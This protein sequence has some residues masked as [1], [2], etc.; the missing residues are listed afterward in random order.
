MLPDHV[1]VSPCKPLAY[2]PLI[3]KAQEVLTDT[4]TNTI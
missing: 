2:F 3:Q 1:R 4:K